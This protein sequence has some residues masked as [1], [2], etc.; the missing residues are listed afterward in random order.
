MKVAFTAPM[1]PID[2]P[3]PSGD[4]TM[5][6]L[7]VRALRLAGHEVEVASSFR[8]WRAHGGEDVTREVKELALAEAKTIAE[9][10]IERGDVPDVFLTYHLYHKAPDWIGPYLCAKFN[11]PYV[12]V[13]ASRAPKRQSGNWALGFNAADAALAQASQVVALTNSDALCLKEV[14]NEDVL[15]VLP[16][17]VETAK[18]EVSHSVTKGSADGKI[19]LLCAGMMREGDKQFSY[20]VLAAALKQIADLPWRLTIAGDGPARGEI[21]PLFDR[22]RIDFVGLIPWQEMPK[23]YRSHDV[24]VW[25]AVR[26]AFGFVFLEAQ[27]CGLPVVGGR[28]FGVPDIVDEGRTG[29]L[30]DE[31]DA[32][33]LAKNIAYLIN[34]TDKREEM[35]LAAVENI[36]E[37]HSLEAGAR[38]LDKVLKAAID[39]H[40]FKRRVQGG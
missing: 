19:R 3:V 1:K 10:W 33:A 35:G 40:R 2:H 38:G 34:N 12:V 4:R 7:I 26:E 8:S 6:R 28:V 32:S 27:C 14:L 17:F 37:N 29:L 25:P 9:Q 18:F 31:G 13:E 15:T 39:H 24:F 36:H 16:P 21:E 23:L 22:E 30:S 20:M 5:G 11:I